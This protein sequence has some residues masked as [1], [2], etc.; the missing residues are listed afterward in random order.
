MS[1]A[2]D[3]NIHDLEYGLSLVLHILLSQIFYGTLTSRKTI[4]F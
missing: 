2:L 1:H 4:N 3:V